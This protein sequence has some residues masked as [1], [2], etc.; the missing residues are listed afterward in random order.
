MSTAMKVMMLALVASAAA[1]APRPKASLLQTW[2][3][4]LDKEYH[5]TKDTPI[6]RVVKLLDEMKEELG[7]EMDEDEKLYKELACWCNTGSSEKNTQIS[8]A[9]AKIEM[10]QQTIESLSAREGE[11]STKIKELETE[12]AANKEELATATALRDKQA[13]EF[14]G[15]EIDSIQA[16][17]NLKA[18][19]VVLSKHHGEKSTNWHEFLQLSSHT[20]L[21]SHSKV[22]SHAKEAPWLSD[23]R[24]DA[25]QN[26]FQNF[27]S[28]ANF[29]ASDDAVAAR[30]AAAPLAVT[31]QFLQ[32]SDPD[33]AVV[34]RAMAT[35]KAFVQTHSGGPAYSSQ[36]GEILGI[37]KQ[38]KETM[39][40]DL[41]AA[42]K[43]EK[44][45]A[46]SFADLRS[47]KTQEIEEGEKMGEQKE[48]ELATTSMDLAEAKEDLEQTNTALGEFQTFLKNLD[49]TCAEADKN[50]EARKKARLS[51]I[52][53]VSETIDILTADDA[54]DAANGTYS[55]MQVSSSSKSSSA[56]RS[57]AAAVLRRAA[58]KTRSPQ[59]AMLAT[60][61]E[62]DV[63][64]KVKKSIDGLI[65]ELE[66]EQADEVKKNDWCKD[67]LHENEMAT[68]KKD[69]HK[70]DLEAKLANLESTIKTLADEIEAAHAA[71][72][73]AQVDLQRAS[74]D[75]KAENMEFQ[76]TVA[77]QTVTREVLLKALDKLANYYDK[78]SLLQ[79]KRQRQT[80]P[81]PQMEYKPSAGAS[82]IMSMIEKLIHETKE[83]T[84][85]SKTAESEAQKAY[86]TLI[87]DTNDSIKN[88]SAEIMSKTEEK[89]QAKKDHVNTESELMD[90]VSELEDLAKL[91][92]NV[93]SEC[94]YVL[95]NFD[96]RQNARAGEVEALKEAKQIL[97]GAASA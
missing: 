77:D 46:A 85:K 28:T 15:M 67:S 55:F 39:E 35:M 82:G 19:L 86:E 21:A 42:Q 84:E 26:D 87:A 69:D 31:S 56:K 73:Q 8:V 9:E 68:M 24:Q 78:E 61:A 50:F 53:A 70:A 16:I 91:S 62:S 89:S 27:L 54:R 34:D 60:K 75:R 95:K 64:E 96:A 10:L 44:E 33:K 20:K 48:D 5:G 71:I 92:A 90:T 65:A 18:A 72:E 23:M 51:E 58:L 43:K 32:Q 3:K 14:H 81:V 79:Q 57:A 17:E 6:T 2:G 49:A 45:R 41:E 47:A 38:M 66:K 88:L 7:K 22:S 83:I 4:E 37:M 80:P 12:V 11:L 1:V 76:K 40:A 93:H 13:K 36:S 59:L 52:Y 30:E 25:E 63:F 74:E 94:D 97:S 29:D